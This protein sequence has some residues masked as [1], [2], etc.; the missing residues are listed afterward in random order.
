[1]F[2][3]LLAPA[4]LAAGVA[5]GALVPDVSRGVRSLVAATGLSAP[6]P[7][8]PDNGDG[9]GH[10][11]QG[12]SGHGH[13]GQGH[14]G[15]DHGGSGEGGKE[16]PEGAI[17]L[18]PEQIAAAKIE[19]APV[20]KGVLTR[21]LSVP[22]TVVPD[23]DRVARVAAK[24]VGTVAELRKRIGDSVAKGE[25][26]AVLDSREVADAKNDFIAA[27]VGLELQE[28]LF[29]RD[30]ELWDKR[31][32]AEQQFLR[33]RTALV[34]AQLKVDLARQKLSALGVPDDEVTALAI[35]PA[36]RPAAGEDEHMAGLR[37]MPILGLQRYALRAPIS[38]RV[39]ERRVD[40]GSPVNG[41]G[42]E[43]EI[44][45]IA[46]LSRVW[47]ELA[48]PTGDLP[49]VRE[50]QSITL[51]EGPDGA[52]ASGRIVFVSPMLNQETRSA[53][54]VAAI[55]NPDLAWRPGSYATVRVAVA[56]QPVALRLPRSAL[57]SIGGEQVVFV[58]TG[59]GFEKREVVLGKGD[60]EA[61]EVVFGL[62]AGEAVATVN[63]FILK[64]ELGKAE[65]EHV[66]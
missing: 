6:M 39:I 33:A 46:D 38:G 59:S 34:E 15:H 62:D 17:P 29:A 37:R 55:D 21:T 56:E 64:A 5:V 12:H 14:A 32:S 43:K 9:H 47:V 19:V 20:G 22:G 3:F 42:Q 51:A 40:A 23:A 31:V 63:S 44:Y 10:G 57:Q 25:V 24:V 66:H 36:A 48:V 1:M 35:K 53:K 27:V 7:S 50:G 41:E 16:G 54:V 52:P 11:D 4:A 8:G 61:V 13:A 2:R 28:T 49:A 65:A 30:H 45:T 18:T 26:L 60:A 58:R